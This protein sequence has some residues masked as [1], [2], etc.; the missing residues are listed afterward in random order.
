MSQCLGTYN[1]RFLLGDLILFC[2]GMNFSS[3]VLGVWFSGSRLLGDVDFGTSFSWGFAW[4]GF[5][6]VCE[7]G[8]LLG[9]DE[10]KVFSF[11]V[12]IVMFSG[13]TKLPWM[14]RS[15][16]DHWQ[17]FIL[18]TYKEIMVRLLVCGI[19]RVQ[20][21]IYSCKYRNVC[22]LFSTPRRMPP[23]HVRKLEKVS[24]KVVRLNVVCCCSTARKKFCQHIQIIYLYHT[25]ISK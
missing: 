16:Q 3:A 14:K 19:F 18:L 11:S 12:L 8:V 15:K 23:V 25:S 10:T 1:L 21:C 6:W 22:H 17:V 24:S 13:T 2:L 5:A 9:S 20:E 4:C 7:T